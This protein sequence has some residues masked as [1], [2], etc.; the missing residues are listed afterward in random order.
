MSR[1]HKACHLIVSLHIDLKLSRQPRLTS[2][3]AMEEMSVRDAL[4][5]RSV[6]MSRMTTRI[7]QS[8]VVGVLASRDMYKCYVTIMKRAD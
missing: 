1:L 5:S 7:S 6:I 3:L 2:R 8:T 4:F